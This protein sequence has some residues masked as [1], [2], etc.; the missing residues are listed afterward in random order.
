MSVPQLKYIPCICRLTA[1]L[2]DLL[3]HY[4]CLESGCGLMLCPTHT[5]P[6]GT[7]H[8]ELLLSFQSTASRVREVLRGRASGGG[9]FREGSDDEEEEEEEDEDD[10]DSEGSEC[11]MR[12]S[13]NSPA[14]VSPFIPQRS[15]V[16]EHGV[17]LEC[18]AASNLKVRSCLQYWVIG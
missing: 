6:P 17:L 7:V 2:D 14:S 8:S 1:G 9:V 16:I 12:K 11:D 18:N 15:S 4:V 5:T 10:D 3:L 13:A